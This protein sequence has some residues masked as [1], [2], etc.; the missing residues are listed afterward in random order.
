MSFQDPVKIGDGLS[1]IWNEGQKWQKM[2]QSLRMSDEDIKRQLKL[3][4]TR[5]NAIVHEAD[6]D[7]VMN[8]KQSITRQEV[9]DISNFLEILGDSICGLVV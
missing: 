9:N 2:A 5:R 6:L 8:L 4:V 3:I 1:Y 7:P